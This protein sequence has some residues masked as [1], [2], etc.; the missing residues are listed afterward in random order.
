MEERYL[1]R[2]LPGMDVCDQDGNKIG[3]VAQVYRYDLALVSGA[4]GNRLPHEEIVE[5]KTGFLG[6]GQHLYVPIS[7]VQDVTTGCVFLS[8]S[9]EDIEDMGWQDKPSYLDDLR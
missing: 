5:V 9:R 4:Q 3:T 2:I 1:G 8:H 7:A 6:L